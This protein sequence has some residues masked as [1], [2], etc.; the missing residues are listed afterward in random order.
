MTSFSGIVLTESSCAPKP[1]QS[2]VIDFS[3]AITLI[4]RCSIDDS[5]IIKKE[6]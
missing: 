1:V 6:N 4:G 3:K 5:A 2:P